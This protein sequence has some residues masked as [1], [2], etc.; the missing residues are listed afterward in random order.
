MF[1][2]N[3]KISLRQLQVLIML[4]I[5]GTGVIVLPRRAA[6][7]AGAD[8]WIAVSVSA[9]LAMVCTFWLCRLIRLFPGKTFLDYAGTL[10]SRPVAYALSLGLIAKILIG[11]ICELRLFGEI[12]KVILLYNT[13]LAVIILGLLVIS[14]Y[15]AAKG[16]ETR[17]RI[18]QIIIWLIF[19]PLVFVL[20]LVSADVDFTNLLPIGEAAPVQIVR[21]GF[22]C[23]SAFSGLEAILL[24]SPY[25]KRHKRVTSRSVVAVAI[26]GVLLCAITLITISRFGSIDIIGHEWPVLEMMDAIDLPG[27]FIERQEAIIM[28]LW[29]L[30]SFA[31]VNAGLFFG[32]V[33]AHA[34]FKK[35]KWCHYLAALV[36]LSFTVCFFIKDIHLVYKIMDFNFLYLG[37]AYMFVIPLVLNLAAKL[38]GCKYG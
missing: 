18:G 13:P 34:V 19:I 8:G 29:M 24:I 7:F 22:Y 5:F 10:V 17:A 37:T 3:D 26:S 6:D 30:S 21:G 38:R 1:S 36:V 2:A 23:L 20:V 31:T 32:G 11:L 33:A 12:V 14:A 25:L 28:S 9:A 27:T 35:G 16:I 4:D 15:A